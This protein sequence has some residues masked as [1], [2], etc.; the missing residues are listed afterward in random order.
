MHVSDPKTRPLTLVVFLRRVVYYSKHIDDGGI[1][2]EVSLPQFP[3]P[4]PL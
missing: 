2:I 3:A 4:T 1:I